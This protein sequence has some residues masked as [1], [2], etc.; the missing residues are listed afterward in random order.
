MAFLQEYYFLL[1]NVLQKELLVR[2]SVKYLKFQRQKQ[3]LVLGHLLS[4]PNFPIHRK[5]AQF[6]S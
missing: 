5:C 3:N 6:D 2:L 4:A 1:E